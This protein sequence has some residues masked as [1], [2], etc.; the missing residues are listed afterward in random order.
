MFGKTLGHHKV[1]E[2]MGAGGMAVAW[3]N[4]DI[5]PD[6]IRI[7]SFPPSSTV[8]DL[9]V[10]RPCA[11]SISSENPASS[12]ETY[13]SRLYRSLGQVH[14]RPHQRIGRL[15]CLFACQ[16]SDPAADVFSWPVCTM[17]RSL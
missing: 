2:Q 16:A 11:T 1:I 3:W 8:G 9:K 5:H 15:S 6:R 10:E 12:R 13:Y 7:T 17:V 14:K 4:Q